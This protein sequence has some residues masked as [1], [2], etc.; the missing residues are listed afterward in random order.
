MSQAAAWRWSLA[1][2]LVAFLCSWTFGRIPGLRP[3]VDTSGHGPIIA[4]ELARTP[5]E[6]ARLFGVEPCR[7]ALLAAQRAAL[8]LD[9]LAFIP[10]YAAFL[11][12]AGLAAA[13]RAGRAIAAAVLAAALLDQAEG[14]L[15]WRTLAAFPGEQR[16]LDAL[17]WAVRGKFLLLALATLAIG[18]ALLRR[19]R[20]VTVVFGIVIAAG[21]TQALLGFFELPEPGMMGGFKVGWLVLLVAAASAS[22]WPSAFARARAPRPPAPARPSA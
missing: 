5:A 22:V 7:S 21:G 4:L 17:F 18:G 13:G 16:V 11:C 12:C 8:W 1:A 20:R 3:C 9:A 19:F 15:L 2:G 10:T 14:V 6:V